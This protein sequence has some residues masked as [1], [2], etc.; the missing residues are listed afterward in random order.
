MKSTDR[1]KSLELK[2]EVCQKCLKEINRKTDAYFSRTVSFDEDYEKIEPYRI[3]TCGDCI[4]L[5]EGGFA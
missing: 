5:T 4:I 1:H 2:P 3:F